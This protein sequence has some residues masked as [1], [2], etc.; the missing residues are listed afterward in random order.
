MKKFIVNLIIVCVLL[1]SCEEDKAIFNESQTFISFEQTNVDLPVLIDATGSVEVSVTVSSLSESERNIALTIVEEETTAG[2][3]SYTVGSVVIPANSYEGTLKI[4][5]VD[6]NV[7]TDAKTLVLKVD[8][9]E[10]FVGDKNL[11][12]NIFEVCPVDITSFVGMYR[13]KQTT[14]FLMAPWGDGGTAFSDDVVVEV[15]AESETRRK[16]NVVLTPK[17]CG[18]NQVDFLFD[19][20]CNKIIVPT[21]SNACSC[22]NGEEWFLAAQTPSG[23]NVNDDSEFTLIFTEGA[24]GDCDYTPAQTSVTFT[25]Q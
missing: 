18:W 14:P 3:D 20:V 8:A 17:F 13:I 4:D 25:K 16:F 6:N 12:V 24:Q 19:L 22:D 9:T 23:Y 2:A 10:A 21:Q 11:T 7:T 5:G 15:V 1:I